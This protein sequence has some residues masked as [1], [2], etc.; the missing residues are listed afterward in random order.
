[1]KERIM[2]LPWKEMITIGSI[3]CALAVEWG[4]RRAEAKITDKRITTLET[5][6]GEV[7]DIKGD[8][9]VIRQQLQDQSKVL[10]RLE[11]MLWDSKFKQQTDA[12]QGQGQQPEWLRQTLKESQEARPLRRRG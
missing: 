7:S 4:V 10:D 5:G 8:M 6:L 9:K 3:I 12:S 2:S 1:M 11:Q